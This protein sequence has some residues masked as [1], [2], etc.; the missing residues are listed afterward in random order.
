MNAPEMPK[1]GVKKLMESPSGRR[2]L[3]KLAHQYKA[4]I[5]QPGQKGF[6]HMYGAKIANDK[7][8]AE[9]K[10]RATE[11]EWE[12][13]RWEKERAGRPIGHDSKFY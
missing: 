12:R 1:E 8:Q 11:A 2:Y 6:D 5:L 10:A 7:R 13:H 3:E 9:A 4:D